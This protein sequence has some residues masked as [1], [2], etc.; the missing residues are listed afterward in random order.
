VLDSSAPVLDWGGEVRRLEPW[1]RLKRL[2]RNDIKVGAPPRGGLELFVF[3]NEAVI[4]IAA[5][6]C[7]LPTKQR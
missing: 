6:G 4:G 5:V 1:E 2:R 3:V 7:L